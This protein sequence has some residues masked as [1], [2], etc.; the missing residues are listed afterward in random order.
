MTCSIR[1][2]NTKYHKTEGFSHTQMGNPYCRGPR[3]LLVRLLDGGYSLDADLRSQPE[4]CIRQ[5]QWIRGTMSYERANA[6]GCCPV[7]FL[8]VDKILSQPWRRCAVLDCTPAAENHSCRPD[9]SAH[10]AHSVFA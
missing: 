6:K 3:Y 9:Q 4:R 1:N 5:A 2:R 7:Q 10:W 8:H